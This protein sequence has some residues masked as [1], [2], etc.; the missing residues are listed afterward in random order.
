MKRFLMFLFC[1][2][3]LMSSLTLV[4]SADS[5][6]DGTVNTTALSYFTGV[7]D[8][9]PANTDYVIYKSGDYTTNLVYGELILDSDT[10]TSTNC[11]LLVYNQRGKAYGNNMNQYYPTFTET[12]LSGFQLSVTSS[13]ILYSNLGNYS[14]LGETQKDTWT[15]ILWS[16]IIL[17]FLFVVY[18]HFRNRR[19]YINLQQVI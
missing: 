16:V 1:A 13:S 14:A 8:K 4:I 12:S 19:Q 15:Y 7:V 3:I 17:I 10:F 18:K 9:L 5:P 6:E 2:A 11:T